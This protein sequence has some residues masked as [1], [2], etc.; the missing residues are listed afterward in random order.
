MGIICPFS[1]SLH[2]IFYGSKVWILFVFNS[3]SIC[4]KYLNYG[5]SHNLKIKA[6]KIG[7]VN[8]YGM[9]NTSKNENFICL[10]HDHDEVV[11]IELQSIKMRIT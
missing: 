3:G 10:P 11:G 2:S 8:P 6:D 1:K 7:K 9:E 4:G 5:K